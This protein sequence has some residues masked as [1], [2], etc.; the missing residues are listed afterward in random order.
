MLTDSDE[1]DMI[2]KVKAI[3]SIVMTMHSFD[4]SVLELE[5]YMRTLSR[6]KPQLIENLVEAHTIDQSF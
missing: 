2:E 3:E 6:F 5:N 4:I 1:M